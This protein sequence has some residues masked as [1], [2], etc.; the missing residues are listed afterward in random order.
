M[1]GWLMISVSIKWTTE[2]T[3]ND[4]YTVWR[5]FKAS[6]FQNVET[7]YAKL[8]VWILQKFVRMAREP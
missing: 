8:E 6:Y 1:K 4:L 3:V 7:L 5:S 2:I